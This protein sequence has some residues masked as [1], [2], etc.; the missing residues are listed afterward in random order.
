MNRQNSFK[1]CFKYRTCFSLS[2]TY[3]LT[4]KCHHR[5]VLMFLLYKRVFIDFI[6][7]TFIS[8]ISFDHKSF[9]KR[10]LF[11]FVNRKT[12]KWSLNQT[13]HSVRGIKLA[14]MSVNNSQLL[15]HVVTVQSLHPYAYR[16][17][18]ILLLTKQYVLHLQF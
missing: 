6:F 4:R 7:I 17:P 13:G 14:T 3:F 5:N 1:H 15:F 12:R 9:I 10:S 8:L 2:I 18:F 16:V 11:S